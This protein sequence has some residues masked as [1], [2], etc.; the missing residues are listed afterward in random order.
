MEQTISIES[1]RPHKTVLPSGAWTQADVEA[2]FAMHFADLMF[3]AQ[4]VHREHF[5]P[6]EVQ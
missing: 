6:N 4:Q 2:L 1:L 3:R 5:D